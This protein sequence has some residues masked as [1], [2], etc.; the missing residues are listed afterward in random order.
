MREATEAGERAAWAAANAIIAEVQAQ[1]EAS[2]A[3]VRE[4][5]AA[6]HR[7]EQAMK[8]S[9]MRGVCAL[10]LEVGHL[11][12][13]PPPPPSPS[14]APSACTPSHPPPSFLL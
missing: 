8:R 12:Y 11:H 9:F 5:N 2:Q 14:P 13:P 10:N 6:K 3:E 1:L 4:V 7:M